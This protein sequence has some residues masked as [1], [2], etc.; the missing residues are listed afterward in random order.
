MKVFFLFFVL[1]EISVG[2]F[3]LCSKSESNAASSFPFKHNPL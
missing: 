3:A 1:R 2:T